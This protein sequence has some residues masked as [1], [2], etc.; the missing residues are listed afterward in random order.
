MRHGVAEFVVERVVPGGDG[1]ARVDGVVALVPGV[2]PGDRVRARLVP[3]GSSLLRGELLAVVEA[4]PD[5]RPETEVCP[6]ALDGSCGGCDWAAARPG[7]NRALK[8]ALV[9]DAL[10]RVGRL[11]PRS[12]P[13]PGWLGSAAAYR[14]RSR[15]HVDGLG[16]AGFLARRSS[17]V[18]DLEA[19][20]VVS[21][22]LLERLPAVRAA[23]LSAG[24]YEGELVTLEGLDGTPL[25]GE[26]RPARAPRDPEGLLRAL[27]GPLD[28]VRLLD[29]EGNASAERGTTALVLDVDGARF[30]VSVSS[31]FQAN[32][33]LLSGFLGVLRSA[34]APAYGAARPGRAVDLYAGVGFLTRPV[35]EAA[36]SVTAVEVSPSSSDDLRANAGTWRAEGLAPVEVHRSSAEA[37]AAGGGLSGAELVVADP[38]REGLSP[39]VRR[40]ISRAAPGVLVLVSCD[41]ATFARD[42]AFFSAGYDVVTLTL[43]DLFPGT[44][45]VECVARL[46]RRGPAAGRG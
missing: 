29:R 28:G 36:G 27:H 2:F 8:T 9:L 42:L 14:L 34:V 16:R 5:R 35:A 26:L 46:V 43:L 22:T 4:G 39:A 19:C 45:H 11:D 6:R 44:H 18:S 24:G 12:L 32:R 41:P 7:S 17:D 21:G 33:H 25:L 38:P 10:R 1:L 13:S 20:E 30:R 31:F 3:D 15:L 37:F 40:A 23:F